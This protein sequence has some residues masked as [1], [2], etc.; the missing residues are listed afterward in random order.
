MQ[1]ILLPGLDGTGELFR[2]LLPYLGQQALQV[3]PLPRDTSQDYA[4]LTHTILEQLPKNE[5]FVLLG[6]SFSGALALKIANL[7]EA[8]SRR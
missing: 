2:P 8:L 6:E 5:G 7:A 3:L 4:D 1:L